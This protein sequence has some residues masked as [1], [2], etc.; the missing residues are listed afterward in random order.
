MN[1]NYYAKMVLLLPYIKAFME[2]YTR[3]NTSIYFDYYGRILS[4]FILIELI[5]LFIFKVL[6]FFIKLVKYFLNLHKILHWFIFKRW[7]YSYYYFYF[8]FINGILINLFIVRASILL[9]LNYLEYS[10]STTLFLFHL[11]NIYSL[12]FY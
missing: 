5:V 1:I 9:K 7:T 11:I 6:S 8:W 2:S 4:T 3:S 10:Q 12:N